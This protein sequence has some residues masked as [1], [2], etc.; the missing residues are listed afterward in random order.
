[1]TGGH[2]MRRRQPEEHENH[3]RWLVSYADFITLLFA[4]FVVMYSISSVNDGKYRVLSNTMEA[5]FKDQTRS[6]DPVQ[7]GEVVRS[8][9]VNEENVLPATGIGDTEEPVVPEAEQQTPSI[10]EVPPEPLPETG[11]GPEAGMGPEK[12]AEPEKPAIDDSDDGTGNELASLQTIADDVERNMA[13]LIDED[14]IEV[15]REDFWIEVEM[16]TNTLFGSGSARL[17]TE[18]IPILRKL[19][20]NFKAYD[21]PIQVEGFTDNLP[22]NT[23]V[24]PSNWELSAARAASVVH[25]FTRFGIDPVRLSAIGYGEY[26]TIADNSTVE[27]RQK[28]RRVVIIIAA[29]TDTRRIVD[30]KRVA[31]PR[32]EEPVP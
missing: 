17:E 32:Q 25:L 14:M 20:D 16:K 3:E 11:M 19:S 21:N 2:G 1:M 29:N 10:Q 8:M 6:L 28:N 18:A 5:V 15:R 13:P 27:G 23:S 9:H 12:N 24:Y 4:F 30:L 26:R 7:M 31:S 22:I